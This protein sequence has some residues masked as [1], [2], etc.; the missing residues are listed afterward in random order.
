MVVLMLV[1]CLRVIF[2]KTQSKK[3]AERLMEA[4]TENEPVIKA[5]IARGYD[6]HQ[7][8]VCVR[9]F[10]EKTP[11]FVPLTEERLLELVKERKKG[12]KKRVEKQ[13]KLWAKARL[14]HGAKNSMSNLIHA[15]KTMQPKKMEAITREEVEVLIAKIKADPNDYF[16][17]EERKT[18]VRLI[19]WKSRRPLAEGDAGVESRR[20]DPG[21]KKEKEDP[22]RV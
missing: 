8:H 7:V 18:M 20:R 17:E 11:S 14:S 2:T 21:R 15:A 19:R 5:V 6:H 9:K 22:V 10:Y 16:E 13:E 4:V 3:K 1:C 12:E